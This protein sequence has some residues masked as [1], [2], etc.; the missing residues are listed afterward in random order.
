MV[1]DMVDE[2]V[3]VGLVDVEVTADLVVVVE[4]VVSVVTTQMMTIRSLPLEPL[5]TR[6]LLKKEIGPQKDVAMVDHEVPTAEVVVEVSTMVMLVK[7]DDPEEH[8]NATV[9]LGEGVLLLP[10]DDMISLFNFCFFISIDY[11]FFFLVLL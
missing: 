4:V 1:V 10:Y 3:T 8:L 11:L 5:K 9:A 7:R 2:E 6:V